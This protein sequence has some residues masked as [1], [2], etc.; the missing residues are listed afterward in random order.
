MDV[1]EVVGVEVTAECVGEGGG[2]QPVVGAVRASFPG[3]G[4]VT[5]AT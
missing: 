5:S 1:G 2:G 4:S 3:Y